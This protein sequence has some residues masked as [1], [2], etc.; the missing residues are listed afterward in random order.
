MASRTFLPA[1]GLWL[2]LCAP[3]P[4]QTP[5]YWDDNFSPTLASSW[6][7]NPDG[8]GASP[9]NFSSPNQTFIIRAGQNHTQVFGAWTISGLDSGLVVQD[10]GGLATN[11]GRVASPAFTLEGAATYTHGS[12][13]TGNGT[14]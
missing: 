2:L 1:A 12:P 5:Y 10:G 4:A 8:T 13:V 11:G 3:A 7:V 14:S 6:H 9:P